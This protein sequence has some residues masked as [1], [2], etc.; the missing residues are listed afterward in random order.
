M[1]NLGFT[2]TMVIALVVTLPVVIVLGVVAFS[3]RSKAPQAAGR[4]RRG[5]RRRH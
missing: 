2:E 4:G 3:T 1:G 5:A